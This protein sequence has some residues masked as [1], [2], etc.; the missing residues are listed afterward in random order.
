MQKHWRGGGQD[1]VVVEMVGLVV[2]LP[3]VWVVDAVEVVVR[4]A[5]VVEVVWG[6][7]AV[8]VTG[9]QEQTIHPLSSSL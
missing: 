4:V 6:I 7:V 3:L 2:V 1:S 9:P 8:V 5:G